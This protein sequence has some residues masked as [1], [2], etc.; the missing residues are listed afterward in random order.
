MIRTLSYNV[1]YGRRLSSILTW[2]SKEFSKY[3]II[4][5]QEYPQSKLAHLSH[6]LPTHFRPLFAHAFTF[7][8]ATYGQ[9]TLYDESVLHLLKSTILDLGTSV[10]ESTFNLNKRP[11]TALIT[12]FQYQGKEI[13]LTNTHLVCAAR[14]KLR[15]RQLSRILEYLGTQDHKASVIL[16]DLNYTSFVRQRP[17]LR[18]MSEHQYANAYEAMTHH[19]LFFKHQVDYAFFKHCRVQDVH[20]GDSR[21]SDHYPISF[22]IHIP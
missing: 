3:D 19:M 9:L 17:L 16:G 8:K 15:R 5:L 4:C 2:M 18:L 6:F 7:A 13:V 1:H 21:L 14:N 12:Q 20:V 22:T 10:L 11:R